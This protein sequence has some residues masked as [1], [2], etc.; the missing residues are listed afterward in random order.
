MDED[1]KKGLILLIWAT[2]VVILSGFAIK[3][4][5]MWFIVPLG[6]PAIGVV[7]AIGIRMLITYIV[8]SSN[9]NLNEYKEKN[10][11][12][13]VSEMVAKPIVFLIFTWV[14]HLFI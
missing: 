3:L 2:P 8:S 5:W 10:I 4:A 12:E 14:I 11:N 7:H 6:V 9:S 13:L 1:I